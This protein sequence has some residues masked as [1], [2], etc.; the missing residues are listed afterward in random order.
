[1]IVN[2]PAVIDFVYEGNTLSL[3]L[4]S[5]SYLVNLPQT[6][7]NMAFIESYE[8]TDNYHA[9]IKVEYGAKVSNIKTCL[10]N[11]EKLGY[12]LQDYL[13]SQEDIITE[14]GRI[15]P[16]FVQN[17]YKIVAFDANEI[18]ISSITK[19]FDEIIEDSFYS[20]VI[21]YCVVE[22]NKN[23]LFFK[24]LSLNKNNFVEFDYPEKMPMLDKTYSNTNQNGYVYTL[25]IYGYYFDKV[26]VSIVGNEN[27]IILNNNTK[28]L[29]NFVGGNAY[30][31]SAKFDISIKNIL[32]KQV[33]LPI[34]QISTSSILRFANFAGYFI[35]NGETETLVVDS[36]GKLLD[37]FEIDKEITLYQKFD[38]A[39]FNFSLNANYDNIKDNE[40]FG[41]E[42]TEN[43][44]EKLVEFD[45]VIGNLPVVELENYNFVGYYLSD[46]NDISKQSKDIR[47]SDENGKLILGYEKLYNK[48]FDESSETITLKNICAKYETKMLEISI[49]T[50]NSILGEVYAISYL[51]GTKATYKQIENGYICSIISGKDILISANSFENRATFAG[52]K[53][54]LNGID[55]TS[56][57]ITD[58]NQSAVI[59]NVNENYEIVANFEEI[60]YS[61]NYH[62]NGKNIELSPNT[63]SILTN[64]FDL[65]KAESYGQEFVGWYL[66]PE[67]VNIR[68]SINP[69][70]YLK[71][72]DLYARFENVSTK[73]NI[74][75][76]N[77]E[78]YSLYT[79]IN[80]VYG[81]EIELLPN[82]VLEGYNFVGFFTN[83]NGT[84]IKID[85][86]S[87]NIFAV[88]T[89]VYAY[90]EIKLASTFEGIGTSDSP[91]LIK[92]EQDF[93]TFASLANYSK[94]NNRIFFKLANSIEISKPVIINSFDANFDGDNN[95]IYV[96]NAFG[97]YNTVTNNGEII[98]SVSL[99]GNNT[100]TIKNLT[101]VANQNNLSDVIGEETLTSTK[102]GYIIDFAI[103]SNKNSGEIDN[104][105]TYF[106]VVL[107]ELN[108]G[109]ESKNTFNAI[110]AE[111][112]ATN[113]SVYNSKFIAKDLQNEFNSV[114]DS[115]LLGKTT[116]AIKTNENG[117]YEIH[118]TE[119][120]EYLL[121]L[122][123]TDIKAVLNANIN[124]KGKIFEK[125]D[126]NLSI[127]ANGY[128]ISGIMALNQDYLF[129]NLKIEKTA[130]ENA[131]FINL[132]NNNTTLIVNADGIENSYITIDLSN[133]KNIISSNNQKIANSYFVSK[134]AVT[135]VDNLSGEICNVYLINVN[136][137]N[138][139]SAEVK[140]FVTFD[141][142]N[143][144]NVDQFII[145]AKTLNETLAS[146]NLWF[147]DS[148]K[149]MSDYVLPQLVKVGNVVTKLIFD[150]NVID[151]Y[152]EIEKVN[153][154]LVITKQIENILLGVSLYDLQQN[155]TD[156][157]VNGES[158]IGEFDS[159]LSI[160]MLKNQTSNYSEVEFVTSLNKYTLTIKVN[161]VGKG[162]LIRYDEQKAETITI[163]VESGTDFN[164]LNLE[165]ICADGYKFVGYDFEAEE[166][167]YFDKNNPIIECNLI[168]TANFEKLISYKLD[169]TNY[170]NIIFK[171][172]KIEDYW[173]QIE[174]NIYQIYL[175]KSE[176]IFDFL[177]EISKQDY[178][179]NRYS[180]AELDEENFMVYAIFNADYVMVIANFDETKGS[181]ELL[182]NQEFSL[183]DDTLKVCYKDEQSNIYYILR[184]Y[185]GV[186]YLTFNGTYLT[187]L[188]LNETDLFEDYSIF[189]LKEDDIRKEISFDKTKDVHEIVVETQNIL[190]ETKFE[191]DSEFVSL[192]LKN[193]IIDPISFVT[194]TNKN[195]NLIFELSIK[196]GKELDNIEFVFEDAD[197][198]AEYSQENGVYVYKVI[199][200]AVIKIN[201]KNKV[202]N[203][204][205]NFQDG[206]QVDVIGIEKSVINEHKFSFAV[207]YDNSA[208][209]LISTFDGYKLNSISSSLGKIFA[210]KPSIVLENLKED[211]EINITFL[212]LNTWLD[213]DETNQPKYFNLTKFKG[214][215]TENNPY[216]ISNIH[217]FL[218]LAYNVNILNKDYSNVYF[219]SAKR[220]LV[221]NLSRYY[222]VPIN[223]FNG[224]ILGDNLTLSGITIS[225]NSYASL[226][227]KLDQN[228]Y[229]KSINITGDISGYYIVAG[230]A[231]ENFGTIIGCQNNASITN[232]NNYYSQNNITAGICAI[233]R[234]VVSRCSN[235]GV[236]NS[237]S[238]YTGGICAKNY[239]EINNVY[240]NAII[241]ASNNFDL[242]TVVA[243]ICAQNSGIVKIG[244]N[245]S[246]LIN[247][248]YNE[249]IELVGTTKNLIGTY[250]DLYFNKNKLSIDSTD[251]RTYEEMLNS[252]NAIYANFSKDIWEFATN[253][254]AL[255]VLKTMY[256]YLGSVSIT[257]TFDESL[258]SQERLVYFVLTNAIGQNYGVILDSSSKIYVISN[259]TKGD[260][261]ISLKNL[262]GSAVTLSTESNITLDETSGENV[263]IKITLSKTSANGYYGY[264]II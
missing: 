179:F 148:N 222:F 81:K 160:F 79:S 77:I 218:T 21:E 82:I 3:V 92:S 198:V 45:S 64:K 59:K 197:F 4:D 229:I 2:G 75:S 117:E 109:E 226:F 32:N 135:L 1:M 157:I 99:F 187:K 91:Y 241:Y 88:E 22:A 186:V 26:S 207:D 98:K 38:N 248:S 8:L 242:E 89:N 118:S 86:N 151:I 11:L 105:I 188:T 189:E 180:V 106:N 260:Y 9:T 130:I 55:I 228:A 201:I 140:N 120:F 6:L 164:S 216:I 24:G 235:Q 152:T 196:E 25:N 12:T 27:T 214:I 63:Y 231:G 68:T 170:N 73:I 163:I 124:L 50:S 258:K 114:L 202:V 167:Y 41:F 175:A 238:V 80:A 227:R 36:L 131:I 44:F 165:A 230:I 191:F 93:I 108:F 194:K 147:V 137:F 101:I 70:E 264:I 162:N 225:S 115:H 18:E 15:V 102:C 7:T 205:V 154:N 146:E 255:P 195:E 263:E 121:T 37:A 76:N 19:Y 243:G 249:N 74:Y 250:E 72:L 52:F 156:I 97:G 84:G 5:S 220:D 119:E 239:S 87:L 51:G 33:V 31:Q 123:E 95:V 29:E 183:Y 190:V 199:K 143:L 204:T 136:K 47:I 206:G 203:V 133:L 53:V 94:L 66:E 261:K 46:N 96:N 42:K 103:I 83:D 139:S 209:L 28:N 259:L 69:V 113:S 169:L 211:V 232:N 125:L 240:N 67:F 58:Q 237:E 132:N 20:Q 141:L 90:F 142:T 57:V 174:T 23:G 253:N 233:N 161:E 129:K 184:G 217:D 111:T 212:K 176:N 112:L 166:G 30:N 49:K 78:G 122:T 134:N 155:V 17:Q 246:R 181:F 193:A 48:Y 173:T 126:K 224:T 223:N 251:A 158:K 60:N 262:L 144:E 127:N 100:G 39:K 10:P 185:D 153:G 116:S 104:V 254:N 245:D 208:S 71:D 182:T 138:S 128:I 234:G 107:N 65:P 213:V 149:V 192:A 252:E 257:V 168:A 200:P 43:G 219:K 56:T 150:E 244:Y 145:D 110:C 221:L 54:Y 13:F 236:I 247:K 62:V 16:K 159:I 172:T 177:P 61:I 14:N 40:L 85:N 178:I 210:L 35:K 256:E 171:D 215:G 34:P